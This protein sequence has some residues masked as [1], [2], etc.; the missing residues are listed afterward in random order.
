MYDPL[1]MVSGSADSV[2]LRASEAGMCSGRYRALE[3][4]RREAGIC[5]T[6]CKSSHYRGRG[7]RRGE[8]GGKVLLGSFGGVTPQAPQNLKHAH[9]SAIDQE[10]TKTRKH[11]VPV[12]AVT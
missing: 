8:G 4:R 5:L 10:A 7:E 9:V 1:T 2:A 11:T 12:I 6:R 3:S